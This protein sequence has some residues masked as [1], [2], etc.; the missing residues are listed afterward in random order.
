MKKLFKKI[1]YWIYIKIHIIIINVSLALYNIENEVLRADPNDLD[2]THKRETRKLHRNQTL[3]KF[4]QGQTDEKYVKDYYEILKKADKFMRNA[5]PREMALAADKRGTNYGMKDHLGRTFEH[6]GFFDDKHKHAGKTVAEV[7]KIELEERRTTDDDL[8]LL[9][10]FN[11]KPIVAS[12]AKILDEIGKAKEDKL[13]FEVTAVKSLDFPLKIVRDNPTCVNKIEQL[14]EFMHIKKIGFEY[15]Q[16]EFFIPRKFRTADIPE[17]DPIFKEI[18]NI[19]E[20]YF[21]DEYGQLHG[22]GILKYIKRIT[23]KDTH[24]VLKFEGIEME[25]VGIH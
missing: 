3:E 17:D 1:Y 21:R 22:F 16:L 5:T 19:K 6:Y 4:Y 24:E 10:I 7:T 25:N 20:A 2:E 9:G 23:Y 15:R 18:I 14:T 12:M 13:E 8:E 11:N